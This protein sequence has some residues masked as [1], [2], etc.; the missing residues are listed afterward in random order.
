MKGNIIKLV[1]FVCLIALTLALATSCTERERI[2]SALENTSSLEYLDCDLYWRV[3]I[4]DGIYRDEYK[5]QE[6][7]IID[8]ENINVTS[9][10]YGENDKSTTYTDGKNVYLSNGEVV[11]KEEYES[12]SVSLDNNVRGLLTT[13]PKQ[14]FELA[15]VDNINGKLKLS[16]SLDS[17][18]FR[19]VLDTFLSGMENRLDMMKEEGCTVEYEDTL[20]EI[21][22]LDGYVTQVNVSYTVEKKIDKTSKEASV[23]LSLNINEPSKISK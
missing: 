16:V 11:T 22:V 18:P 4:K 7:I 3:N 20:L 21:F 13:H 17:V 12:K 19:A 15:R 9:W 8:K 5:V 23:T 1:A 14:L 2:N 10:H 6:K